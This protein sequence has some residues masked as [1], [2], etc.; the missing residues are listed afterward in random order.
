MVI[1]CLVIPHGTF[2]NTFR[3]HIKRDMDFPV[4]SA[5]RRQNAQLNRIQ[6]RPCVSV[7]DIC[8]KFLCVRINHSVIFTHSPL[9][10]VHCP[11]NQYLDIILRQRLQLKYDRAR[12]QSA[13]HLKIR[14]FG[15]CAHQNQ[16]PILHKRKQ[17]VLLPLIEAVNLIYKQNRPL[18]VHP[19]TVFR[20][21][22][23]FF[24]I[25]FSRH[26]S[27][28][29]RKLRAGSIGY[30][31]RKRRFPCSRRTI[32]NDRAYLIRLNRTVKQLVLSDNML[33]SYH[34]IKSLWAQPGC[35]RRLR[36]H[37]IF[38]HIIK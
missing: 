25:F 4:A 12:N 35:Q 2:L 33:L 27:I 24:H 34:L 28:N 9:F 6:R 5:L 7:R 8:Q 22:Y 38:P 26:R 20:G 14:I 19:H 1:P 31:L 21:L 18:P 30:D 16:R 3:R 17:I 15:S 36:L 32:E 10:V 37:R 13:V 23:H 29:L 11:L